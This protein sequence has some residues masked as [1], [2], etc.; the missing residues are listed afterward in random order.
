M[1]N[2]SFSQINSKI[3]GT[4]VTTGNNVYL[5][6]FLD[7]GKVNITSG[8]NNGIPTRID[9]G[10]R[11]EEDSTIYLK[12]IRGKKSIEY[13][14]KIV[15]VDDKKMIL[16]YAPE[17]YKMVFYKVKNEKRIDFSQQLVVNHSFDVNPTLDSICTKILFQEND[18]C[19]TYRIA[20]SGEIIEF[21]TQWKIIDREDNIFLIIDDF[22]IFVIKEINKDK[23]EIIVVPYGFFKVMT[24]ANYV[25]L[26][27]SNE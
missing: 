17:N 25:K 13:S 21:K 16:N 1:S 6:D 7:S 3:L 9:N 27:G 12:E 14:C 20:N 19:K 11:I 26:I 10:W 8:K 23:S 18:I 24:G 2:S 22:E 5:Y 4:W 15:E